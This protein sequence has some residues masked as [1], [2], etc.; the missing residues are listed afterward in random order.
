M[1]TQFSVTLPPEAI[2]EATSQALMG[3][4]TP[5]IKDRI[6]A[7]AITALLSQSSLRGQSAIQSAFEMAVTTVAQR[8]ALK[9]VEEDEVVRER[10]K[11]LIRDTAD[12]VLN[13]SPEKLV[14]KMAASFVSAIKHSDY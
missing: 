4:L 7:N 13:T 5:E 8:E 9:M 2:Q 10:I 14:E 3:M 11:D 1:T 6:L 12:K